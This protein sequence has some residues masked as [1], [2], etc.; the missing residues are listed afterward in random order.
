[1]KNQVKKPFRVVSKTIN[2][3]LW[4]QYNKIGQF[5]KDLNRLKNAAEIPQQKY[6]SVPVAD[7]PMLF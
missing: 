7:L 4:K 2:S 1:M 3:D 5:A 6:R